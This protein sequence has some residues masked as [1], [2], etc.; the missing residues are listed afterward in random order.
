MWSSQVGRLPWAQESGGSNPS[1]RIDGLGLREIDV[2][3]R[4]CPM[5]ASDCG[6]VPARSWEWLPGRPQAKHRGDI[7][8]KISGSERLL[9]VGLI[10]GQIVVFAGTVTICAYVVKWIFS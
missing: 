7:M 9:I 2:D 5:E 3:G 6:S 1:T 4:W 10:F 8:R